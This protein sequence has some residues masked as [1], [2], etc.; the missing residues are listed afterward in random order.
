MWLAAGEV[1]LVPVWWSAPEESGLVPGSQL[2][3]S[4]LLNMRHVIY[5]TRDISECCQ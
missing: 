5:A 3:N 4:R 1:C 2:V